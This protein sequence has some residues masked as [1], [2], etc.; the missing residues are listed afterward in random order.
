[1]PEQELGAGEMQHGDEVLDVTLP[2]RD[3]RPGEGGVDER[4]GEVDL[5]A[6][7]ETFGESLQQ[8]LQAPCS[9][10]ELKAAM[11]GLMGRIAAGQIVPRRSR[12]PR[13]RRADRRPQEA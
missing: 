13:T 9:L 2:A 11:T 4:F 7:T 3:F 8:H 5:A 12:P 6:I 10:P 1:M